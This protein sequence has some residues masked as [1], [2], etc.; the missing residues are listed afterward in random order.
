MKI[1]GISMV[2]AAGAALASGSAASGQLVLQDLN[3]LA[4][5]NVNTQA[6]QHT[7]LVDGIDH[8]FQQWFW[9]RA[10]GDQFERSIDTIPLIGTQ[11][12][13]TNFFTDPRPDTLVGLWRD[14]NLRFNIE[15]TV[16]LR[17]STP[18]SNRS[19]LAEQIRITNTTTT[20]LPFHFFQ[21]VD[22]DLNN[23]IPDRKSVV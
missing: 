14:A 7:W 9:Y 1:R 16:T 22:L 17:G 11:L 12:T 21:Y 15:L 10:G 6:G 19:D 5:F 18:N 3:S 8:M 4:D 2:V 23:T 20:I 13:D